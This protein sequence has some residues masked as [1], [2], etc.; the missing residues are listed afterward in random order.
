MVQQLAGGDKVRAWKQSRSSSRKARGVGGL[1]VAGGM[2]AES[3]ER[4]EANV[5]TPGWRD[6]W[7]I[8]A[9]RFIV[10]KWRSDDSEGGETWQVID[11]DNCA[12]V[13]LAQHRAQAQLIADA[14][15]YLGHQSLIDQFEPAIREAASA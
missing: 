6:G 8:D 11:T 14:L 1:C 3:P 5:V 10:H 2:V 9:Q 12:Q 13:G 7:D 15:E 4:L